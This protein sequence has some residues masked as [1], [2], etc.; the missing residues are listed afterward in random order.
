MRKIAL[1]PE[2]TVSHEAVLK[3]F[4][5]S[6]E[7]KHYKQIA[8]VFMAVATGVV[9]Y[10]A[11]P[12]ENTIEGTVSLH[13]DW[14]VHEVDVPIQV[15]WVYPSIQNLIG[16][17]L[18]FMRD[19]QLDFSQITRVFS[20][21][22]AL[23]QCQQFIRTYL[24]HAELES[25]GST[26]EAIQKVVNHSDQGWAAIGTELGAA[27]YGLD[28]LRAEVTDH[29][30]NF[31]R[32]ILIGNEP[33]SL[34]KPQTALKTSMIVTLPSDFPGAL[35]QVLSAFAWRQLNLARIESRPTKK[36]LGSYYFYLDVLEPMD[37]ILLQ[38]AIEEIRALGF[39]VR[40]LGSYPSYSFGE[41]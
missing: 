14:L 29:N 32:F 9:D 34:H 7:F 21:P 16:S 38:S 6:V 8:D 15:E 22:V 33:C 35:H 13:M 24:P 5:E 4:G 27:R 20:H 26:A 30:H 1:L 12:V 37:S 3:L 17:E 41:I 11:I 36:M 2:G 40:I 39:Q 25:V 18:E 10:S 23:A 31:T 19:G 28:I